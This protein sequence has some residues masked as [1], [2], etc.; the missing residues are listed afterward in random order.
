MLLIVSFFVL[1]VVRTGQVVLLLG[2][3]SFSLVSV[4][5]S[6][7]SPVEFNVTQDVCFV[8]VRGRLSFL[9]LHNS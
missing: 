8:S 3:S 9:L 4:Q 7:E 1:V 6:W 2:D 5:I